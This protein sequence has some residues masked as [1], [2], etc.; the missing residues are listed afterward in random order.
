MNKWKSKGESDE[1]MWS[2]KKL[3][4]KYL[5][6]FMNCKD[7]DF[8][9]ILSELSVLRQSIQRFNGRFK[10]FSYYN[11]CVYVCDC[12]FNGFGNWELDMLIECYKLDENWFLFLLPLCLMLCT[13]YQMMTNCSFYAHGSKVQTKKRTYKKT[14]KRILTFDCLETFVSIFNMKIFFEY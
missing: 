4:F 10:R 1:Y 3:V 14:V 6:W 7:F 12:L 9:W 5:L 13:P 2:F 11:E 8:N